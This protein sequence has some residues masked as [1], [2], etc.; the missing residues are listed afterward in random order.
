MTDYLIE[1]LKIIL[2]PIAVIMDFPSFVKREWELINL[3][4][5]EKE[6][7]ND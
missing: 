4:T 2:F 1:L 5:E 7:E 6:N 3:Y